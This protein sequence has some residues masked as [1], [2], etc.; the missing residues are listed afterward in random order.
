MLTNTC[1]FV[2]KIIFRRT[3][4]HSANVFIEISDLTFYIFTHSFTPP[5]T[6]TFICCFRF[7]YSHYTRDNI[8]FSMHPTVNIIHCSYINP[9]SVQPENVSR[10][11]SFRNPS[12][13]SVGVRVYPVPW[14]SGCTR[15]RGCS[16]VPGSVGVR[17]CPVPWVS[18]CT[19]Y[20]PGVSDTR[21]GKI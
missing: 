17:V 20:Y 8:H 5:F 4:Q 6:C 13:V 19:Q 2:R 12:P 14:V 21:P 10:E 18:G 11:T 1:R 7:P 16:G 9:L 3:T 15:F